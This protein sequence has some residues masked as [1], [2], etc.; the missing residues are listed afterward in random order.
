M[1]HLRERPLF[2]TDLKIRTMFGS[3]VTHPPK[4][5]NIR[6][7][8]SVGLETKTCFW[9]Q[10]IFKSEHSYCRDPPI[11]PNPNKTYLPV[12]T[13]AKV[14]LGSKKDPKTI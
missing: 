3:V 12:C 13:E 1:I 6:Y 4:N 2:P 14:T 9:N 5:L 10:R 11:H 7:K 8:K